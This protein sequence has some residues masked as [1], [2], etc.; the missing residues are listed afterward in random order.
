MVPGGVAGEISAPRV[1]AIVAAVEPTS[2]VEATRKDMTL[3]H[4]DDLRRFDAQ[5][6]ASKAKART[7]G[8]ASGIGLPSCSASGLSSQRS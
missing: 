2:P 3:E 1:D 8:A 4:L 5:L 7:A 6:K